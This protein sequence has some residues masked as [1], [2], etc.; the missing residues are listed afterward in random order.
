MDWL[1]DCAGDARSRVIGALDEAAVRRLARRQIEAG[2]HFLVPCGTTGETPTL[3]EDERLRVVELIVDEAA[4]RVPVLAGAGGY[5]TK[6]VVARR[7]MQKA[8]LAPRHPLRHP[9]LQQA[10]AGRALSALQHDRR[11]GRPAD[12]RLQRARSNR[13]QRRGRDA[14]AAVRSPGDRRSQGSLGQ[15]HTDVRDLRRG[16]VAVHR[17]VGRRRADACR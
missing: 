13:L 8:R 2:I 1:R 15:R 9:V 6:E 14:R 12:H 11:R 10:D 5:D 16:P 7:R 3:T 4:G 17:A